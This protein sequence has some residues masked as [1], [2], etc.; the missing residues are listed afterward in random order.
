M[1]VF[2]RVLQRRYLFGTARAAAPDRCAIRAAVQF[3]RAGSGMSPRKPWGRLV[4]RLIIFALVLAAVGYACAHLGQ[5]GARAVERLLAD[6]VENGL[7]V[8]GLDWASVRADGLRVEISGHAPDLLARDLALESARSTAPLARIS[9]YM[10]ASLAPPP[11]QDP[12]LVEIL[13][14]DQGLT[15]TGRF[16]GE[17]MRGRLLAVIAAKAPTLAL[18]DL[19]GVNAARPGP[20]WGPELD[21]AAHAAARVPNAFIRIEPGAVR[22]EGLARDEDHRAELSAELLALAA[23]RVRLTLALRK[24]LIVLAPFTFA[25]V[26]STSGGMRLER[27]AARDAGEEAV[28]EALLNRFGLEDGTSHCPA[29]LGGPAGDWPGAV[30]AGVEALAQLPA[31]RFRL[32][33]RAAELRGDSPT[34]Q[35]ELEAGL[36]ALAATLPDG[37]AL[38]GSLAAGDAGGSLA[39]ARARYWMRLARAGETVV[40]TGQVPGVAAR[41]VVETHAAARFG[42]AAVQSALTIGPPAVPPGWE[43]AAMVALDALSEVPAGA[44][45]LND[46][47]L[48]LAARLSDP[49][50][51][52]ALHR[53]VAGEAPEGYRVHTE[54]TIDLPAQMA[55]ARL[56]APRCAVLLGTAVADAPVAFAP[57]SA[58]IDTA[59]HDTLDRLAAIF[60]RCPDGQ[61]EI[62]GHTDSQG[63]E[64][65]N[66]RLSQARAEAVLD[67]MLARG[68][69]LD[70]IA[71]RG[72]GEA[73]PVASNET[74][75]GRTLNR[76][77][78]FKAVE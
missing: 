29:A 22:V 2:L 46:G 61:I 4:R 13:R 10:T 44:V 12:V 14:D 67:A 62:G 75:E 71:A 27:C 23:G 48:A 28:L 69:R 47:R 33:Y 68:V 51:A 49:A 35:A 6:R 78:E 77:I 38:L 55:A 64:T 60:R 45:D 57:G 31:G 66:Q 21:I 5:R 18:H 15:L 11:R 63:S 34:G 42:R 25:I 30:A 19:T 73:L 58:V 53:I 40:L 76:R 72:Y 37:Y 74:E 24:P 16:H 26:K 54:L 20:D 8:L 7:V 17:K 9:D 65:L 59:S 1:A 3:R 50:A 52:G 43:A 70:R 56:T 32:E 39:E 36:V 41:R